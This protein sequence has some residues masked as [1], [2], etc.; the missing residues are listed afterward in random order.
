MGEIVFLSSY[1]NEKRSQ[2]KLLRSGSSRA[3]DLS[4]V[5]D[6]SKEEK[7]NPLVLLKTPS[8]KNF[9]EEDSNERASE[10]DEKKDPSHDSFENEEERQKSPYN[11]TLKPKKLVLKSQQKDKQAVSAPLRAQKSNIIDLQAYRRKKHIKNPRFYLPSWGSALQTAAFAF[12]FMLA[13]H[14]FENEAERGLAQ[15]DSATHYTARAHLK[16]IIKNRQMIPGKK[17]TSALPSRSPDSAPVE[18]GRSVKYLQKITH[19]PEMILGRQPSSS[20]YQGF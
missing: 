3:E 17:D 20:K 19:K 18:K 10:H 6:S 8:L 12:A 7:P 4:F 16:E 15:A 1:S 14:F 5:G 13:F 11:I 2:R 9:V